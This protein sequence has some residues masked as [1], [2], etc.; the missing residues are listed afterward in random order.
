MQLGCIFIHPRVYEI[1]RIHGFCYS[2]SCFSFEVWL[3][4]MIVQF[5]LY[6]WY[7]AVPIGYEIVTISCAFGIHGV[8]NNLLYCS[9]SPCALHMLELLN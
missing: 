5:S 6:P 8:Y 3:H 9:L 4:P 2:T 1:S 7:I